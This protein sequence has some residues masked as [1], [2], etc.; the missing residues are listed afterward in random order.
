MLYATYV[1]GFKSA[2]YDNRSNAHPDPAVVVP[3]TPANAVGAWEFDKEEATNYEIGMKSSIGGVAELN[4]AA[5][6]T[7]YDDLQTSVFDGGVG[8][9][10]ANAAGAEI[11]GVEID[12]RWAIAEYFTL[13]GS[14]GY[15]D[16]EFKDFDVAQCW[17]GQTVLEPDLSL[18]HI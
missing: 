3:G 11:S 13:S 17:F 5:F 7:E 9:N 10:V 15:L 8:F 2:G 1:E 14:L 6:Y 4:I 12:G 16:F 18:I